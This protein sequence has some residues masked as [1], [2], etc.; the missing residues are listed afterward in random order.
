[1]NQTAKNIKRYKSLLPK[2]KER[3]IAMALM[4]VISASLMV[5]A[6]FAWMTLSRNPEVSG[7]ATTISGNGSLEIAL[8]L[9]DGSMPGESKIGDSMVTQSIDLANR[10]WGN[11]INLADP[12]YGLDKL[13]LRPAVLNLNR[14]LVNP[15]QGVD[16]GDDGRVTEYQRNFGYAVYNTEYDEFMIPQ[17]YKKDDQGR[18]IYIDESGNE[19]Y[20]M[21]EEG[22]YYFK[23]AEGVVT[24]YIEEDGSKF[25]VDEAGK[26]TAAGTADVSAIKKGKSVPLAYGVRAVSSVTYSSIVGEQDLEGMANKVFG[27]LEQAE[28]AYQTVFQ[29]DAYLEVLSELVSEYVNSQ[30]DSG[31]DVECK[32]YMDSLILMI[33]DLEKMYETLGEVYCG[34]AEMQQYT[35]LGKGNYTP[36]TT[37][38]SLCAA[39]AQELAAQGISLKGLATYKSDRTNLAKEITRAETLNQGNSVLYSQISPTVEFLCDT[40]SC[41]INNMTMAQLKAAVKSDMLGTIGKF[42]GKANSVVLRKGFLWRTDSQVSKDLYIPEITVKVLGRGLSASVQTDASTD[43]T[44]DDYWAAASNTNFVGLDPTADDTYALALDFWVRSNAVSDFLVL[45]GDV[46]EDGNGDV[47][48]YVGDNRIWEDYLNTTNG[49]ATTQGSGSCYVFTC[50]DPADYD[51]TMNLLKAFTVA[52]VNDQ[53]KVM[54]YAEMDTKHVWA[55]AG[56]YTVPLMIRQEDENRTQIITGTKTETYQQDKVSGNRVTLNEE[57]QEYYYVNENQET[58]TVSQE[59][60]ETIEE[61]V[62]VLEDTYYIT[63]LERNV[64]QKITA[65]VYLDGQQLTNDQV[66]AAAGIEGKLNIQFGGVTLMEALENEKLYSEYVGVSASVSNTELDYDTM[67]ELK[68][69]VTVNVTGDMEATTVTGYFL[70]AVNDYQGVRQKIMEFTSQSNGTWTYEMDFAVPGQYKLTHITVNGRDY[71]LAQPITVTVKGFAMGN[72][73]WGYGD[74]EATVFTG[75]D[76]TSTNVTFAFKNA[77]PNVGSVRALFV[78]DNGHQVSVP[79]RKSGDSEQWAGSANFTASGT[80][81][82]TY[83]YVDEEAYQVPENLG[84]TLRAT[85]GVSASVWLQSEAFGD[86]STTFVME[87]DYATGATVQI[88]A[89]LRDNSGIKLPGQQN[90]KL[91]YAHTSSALL[92][93]DADLTWNEEKGVYE[94]SFFI[95]NAGVYQF[96]NVSVGA[97]AVRKADSAPQIT[98]ISPVPPSYVGAGTNQAYRFVPGENQHFEV[99]IA[100]SSTARVNALLYNGNT[101]YEVQGEKGDETLDGVLTWKFPIPKDDQGKQDGNWT[102]DSLYITNYY[103]ADSVLHS[104][105]PVD[106]QGNYS[107]DSGDWTQWSQDTLPNFQKQTTKIV[108]TIYAVVTAPESQDFTGKFMTDHKINADGTELGLTIQDFE[109]QP[110]DKTVVSI[111]EVQWAHSFSKSKGYTVSNESDMIDKAKTAATQTGTLKQG[112]ENTYQFGVLNFQYAGSYGGKITFKLTQNNKATTY[113]VGEGAVK[114]VGNEIP[115]FTTTWDTPTVKFTK[116]SGNGTKATTEPTNII[117][118]RGNGKTETLTNGIGD[119]YTLTAYMRETWGALSTRFY[120]Y[121][122][123]A[124]VTATAKLE[125][126]SMNFEQAVC[127]FDSGN[128]RSSPVFTFK[129]SEL[130]ATSD[131]GSREEKSGAQETPYTADGTETQNIVVTCDGL[132]YTLSLKNKLSITSTT[133]YYK[134]KTAQP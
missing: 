91:T 5:S 43:V 55:N 123:F 3:V 107:I 50:E 99:Q 89:I 32:Q 9:K 96:D 105:E 46:I 109:G 10:T 78:G 77:T 93:K 101:R 7:L 51:R 28:S 102:L 85:L 60:I 92:R 57:T 100:D 2:M 66:M 116:V 68:T 76:N 38:D 103:D 54:A 23:N 127:T 129:P 14:L 45:E 27:I 18:V 83:I 56:R 16:Y 108:Q 33:K 17:E 37:V 111:S 97:S 12:S 25:T 90:V 81:K 84:K 114:A 86:S 73:T 41:T 131:I 72:I 36:Y 13:E 64:P 59:N 29:N 62:P 34:I 49:Q 95:A 128:E 119:G 22:T 11:L 115:N 4:L 30:L 106:E 21:D 104:A 47:I 58:V 132:K 44:V 26:A 110:L 53:G 69:T 71:A 39:T 82:L 134:N 88:T 94:G 87:E 125:G 35:A 112:S 79:M 122:S 118:G 6:S 61:Q 19:L 8:S 31:S 126:L 133:T 63:Q 117:A 40:N 48:G 75:E 67:D 70:R 52:F 20:C 124:V 120:K 24:H 80:Y 65:L 42:L 1:M 130:E 121:T 98:A 74:N 113:T 15:L